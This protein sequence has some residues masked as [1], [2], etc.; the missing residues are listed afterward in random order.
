[1][2]NRLYEG[3]GFWLG[4][5]RSCEHDNIEHV[6]A[7]EP[8]CTEEGWYEYLRCIECG[9]EFTKHIVPAKGHSWKAATCVAPKT[10]SFCGAKEGSPTAHDWDGKPSCSICGA[11][12]PNYHVEAKPASPPADATESEAP[13]TGI[14]TENKPV[15]SEPESV[16]VGSEVRGT[17]AESDM[18]TQAVTQETEEETGRE[19]VETTGMP[20]IGFLNSSPPVDSWLDLVSIVGAAVLIG[21]VIGWYLNSFLQKK[22]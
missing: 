21:V 12:N 14:A 7:K 10:C 2:Q 4:A 16:N 18:E 20:D 13:V 11:P 5:S 1:M 6:A 9:A 17:E 19:T 3:N 8:T 22:K 15:A